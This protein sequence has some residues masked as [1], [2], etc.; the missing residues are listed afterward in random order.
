M[1]KLEKVVEIAWKKRY[2]IQQ[3]SQGQVVPPE[4]SRIAEQDPA[5]TQTKV[6]SLDSSHLEKHRLMML[7]DDPKSVDCYNL[8]CTKLLQKTRD[9]GLNTIMVTSA[10]EDEGKTITSINLAVSIAREVKQTVMLV[11]TDLRNP[12][13]HHY[14]GCDGQKGL[15]DYLLDD[16]P[17]AKLLVNPGLARMVV[18]A[19]GKRLTGSTEILGSPK[20]EKLVEEMKRRYPERYVIFDCPPLLASPDALIFSSYVDGVILVVKA[21]KTPKDLI[22]KAIELLH[23]KNIIGLVMNCVKESRRA[24]YYY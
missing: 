12:T 1:S 6:I 16:E 11:D 5:Y 3:K 23:G 7:I 9:N 10:L 4:M 22:S 21:G 14:L 15:R 20:M 19:A 8:L 2:G 24:Y 13:I 18:L 17:L